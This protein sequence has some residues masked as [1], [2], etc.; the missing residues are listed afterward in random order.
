MRIEK[1]SL[2]WLPRASLYNEQ[3][4]QR[5]K[6]KAAHQ[7]F[8]DTQSSFASSIGSIQSD[9]QTQSSNLLSQAVAARLGITLKKSA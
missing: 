9:F 5:A 6:Q 7:S 8:L 2:N 3:A 1:R 4:A